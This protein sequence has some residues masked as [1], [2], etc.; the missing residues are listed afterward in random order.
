ME[1]SFETMESSNLEM[2]ALTTSDI[3][4]SEP[5]GD[6]SSSKPRGSAFGIPRREGSSEVLKSS[7][8]H[9]ELLDALRKKPL[10][11]PLFEIMSIAEERSA[12]EPINVPSSIIH[13]LATNSGTS[14]LIVSI[15]E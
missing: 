3:K 4:L 6:P 7:P 9:K 13:W 12:K 14:R 10:E 5:I 15:K 11:G 8:T 2:R 1:E